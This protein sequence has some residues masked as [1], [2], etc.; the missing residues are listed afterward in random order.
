L[1]SRR[2]FTA[3][4]GQTQQH[5]VEKR[6]RDARILNI[7][8]GTNEIQ[9]VFYPQDLVAEVARAGRARRQDRL[10]QRRPGKRWSWKP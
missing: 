5:L 1:N 8:E 3:W 6:K 9:R 7:Y 2:T 4:L 10:P